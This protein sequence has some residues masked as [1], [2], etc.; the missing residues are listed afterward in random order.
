VE[1]H[2][3]LK[4]LTTLPTGRQAAGSKGRHKTKEIYDLQITFAAQVTL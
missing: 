4:R 2:G 3:F 1:R